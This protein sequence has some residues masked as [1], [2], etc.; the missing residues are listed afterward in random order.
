MLISASFCPDAKLQ[1][2][3]DGDVSSNVV[4]HCLILPTLTASVCLPKETSGA[5]LKADSG[6]YSEAIAQWLVI[7]ECGGKRCHKSN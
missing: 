3:F 7:F 4:L 2:A 5:M 1:Q 6:V